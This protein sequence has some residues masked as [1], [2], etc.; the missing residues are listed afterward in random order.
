M[1]YRYIFK[2]YFIQSGDLRGLEEDIQAKVTTAIS[3]EC[4]CPFDASAI[5]D[6]FFSFGQRVTYHSKLLG[7]DGLSASSLLSILKRSFDKD[8][9]IKYRCADVY[10]DATIT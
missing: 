9:L 4:G 10:L 6:A 3:G 8:P 5:K 1:K 2:I 7:V